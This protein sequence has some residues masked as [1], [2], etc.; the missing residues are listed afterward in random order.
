MNSPAAATP[1]TPDWSQTDL[2]DPAGWHP[3]LR[4]T[5]DIMLNSPQAMLLM[6]G[7]EQIMV[8]NQAY[9]DL[10][11]LPGLRA[12]GGKVPSMQPGAWSWNSNALAEARAGRS[13]AYH[14]CRLPLWRNNRVEPQALDLYYTPV[15]TEHGVHGILCTLAPAAMLPQAE[16]NA[17]LRLL[18]V[19]DN[20]DARYLVCETLRALGH[21]VQAVASGEEALP[22]LS[23][24]EF[25]VLFTDVSLPGMSGVDLARHALQRAPQLALLFASGYGD[26]L[27]RHLEFPAQSLQKPYDIE[28]LQAVLE[29]VAAQLRAR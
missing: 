27:T 28:Q 25:D 19:E 21:E 1:P 12:P 14:G 5:T 4:L 11:A 10:V 2:G 18:V 7:P 13:V 29:R 22:L 16:Q 24:Q 26:E 17:P 9:A 20:A 3:S 23:I 15:R 8:Y 6:W